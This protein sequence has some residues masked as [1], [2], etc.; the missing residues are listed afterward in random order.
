MSTRFWQWVADTYL[1]CGL[2]SALTRHLFRFSPIQMSLVARVS[3]LGKDEAV[4]KAHIVEVKRVE[5]FMIACK[6]D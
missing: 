5:L 2:T 4:A 1:A 3:G 6:P